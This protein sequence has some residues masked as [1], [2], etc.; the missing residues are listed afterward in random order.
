MAAPLTYKQKAF[1]LEYR[2]DHNG[3]QAAIRAGYSH[4]GADVAAVRL[5]ADPR[6]RALIGEADTKALE[7]VQKA[8]DRVLT[9]L[10]TFAYS[11]VAE[12]FNEDGTLKHLKDFPEG[13]RRAV[14]SFEVE[15][16]FEG[17]GQDRF[18]V[19]RTVKVTLW[20]KDKGLE[21][22][23]RNQKLFTDKIEHSADESLADLLAAAMKGGGDGE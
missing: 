13:L 12:A 4:R 8:G 7:Q 3:T 15:E 17:T 2:K 11:D 18:K 10:A 1:A 9:E 20:P 14:K 19:G 21:L 16:L 6:I 22:L 23:G 5:L